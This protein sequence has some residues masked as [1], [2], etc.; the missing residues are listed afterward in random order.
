MTERYFLTVCSLGNRSSLAECVDRL[1]QIKRMSKRQISILLVI[2]REEFEKDFGPEVIVRFE[3]KRGY[4]NVRNRAIAELPA[5]SSII[6]VDDDELPTLTWFNQLVDMHEKFPSDLVFGPVFPESG[7][8]VS[9]YR[10]QYTHQYSRMPD[11]ALAKQASTANLLIPSSLIELNMI[12]FDSIFNFSG[13]ED[14]DLCFRLRKK[15][16]KIRFAKEAILHEVRQPERYEQKYLESRFIK[17]I[18]NYSVVI[19]RNSSP[20]LIL[21]RFFTLVVRIVV[22]LPFFFIHRTSQIK[23]MAYTKSLRALL[24]GRV[25][26]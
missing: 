1:L 17:D 7:L 2:N 22:I 3:L 20:L 4:S 16:I 13:S 9:S 23:V 11:G 19:R 24:F 6:F 15:G 21:W 10:D 14:T 25:S 12:H 18:A 26:V 8:G 5:N